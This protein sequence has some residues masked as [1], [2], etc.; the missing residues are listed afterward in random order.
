MPFTGLYVALGGLWGVLWTDL[1]QFILKMAIVIAVAY[2][3]VRAVG[4]MHVLLAQLAAMRVAA[5]P[6]A[7]DITAVLPDFS[8]GLRSTGL[9]TLPVLTFLVLAVRAMVGVL[10]SG[11]GA[12]RRRLRG[13]ANF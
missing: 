9:W 4:G 7:S 8:R 5:G 6:G 13:T 12:G 2:Y 1:F 11:R 10:V 3:G